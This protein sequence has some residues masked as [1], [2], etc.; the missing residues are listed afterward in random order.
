MIDVV[1]E[2]E[3]FN[4]APA[5]NCIF[6]GIPTRMWN[7]KENKPVCDEPKGGCAKVRTQ[8]EVEE[9]SYGY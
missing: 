4:D 1:K 8:K 3:I 7:E 9:H 6:C 5:E 2:P